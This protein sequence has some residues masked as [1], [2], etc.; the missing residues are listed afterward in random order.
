M[1]TLNQQ[2]KHKVPLIFPWEQKSEFLIFVK[3]LDLLVVV[4]IGG[5]SWK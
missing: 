4:E 2:R 3:F 1:R 5:E